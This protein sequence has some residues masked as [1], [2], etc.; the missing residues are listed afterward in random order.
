RCLLITKEDKF[1][2]WCPKNSN[3]PNF[4]HEMEKE[5]WSQH[6]ED[7]KQ[8]VGISANDEWLSESDQD[9]KIQSDSDTCFLRLKVI[10]DNIG[11]NG[12]NEE[13]MYMNARTK[14]GEW[15]EEQT[16]TRDQSGNKFN[17]DKMIGGEEEE[18][19][20]TVPM[21]ECKQKK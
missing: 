21:M 10:S 3:A 17:A 8:F 9:K 18:G 11:E 12:E 13:R 1:M 2:T 14:E 15:E 6:F 20:T 5:D 19:K 16:G 4:H 7:L